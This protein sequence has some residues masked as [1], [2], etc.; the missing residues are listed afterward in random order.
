MADDLRNA[1][2]RKVLRI[3][4]N[5]A[6]GSP[7][8]IPASAEALNFRLRADSRPRPSV[9]PRLRRRR[10][11][12]SQ[13]L[14]KLSSIHFPRSFASG[15]KNSHPSIVKGV[16]LSSASRSVSCTARLLVVRVGSDVR[17]GSNFLVFILQ[18]IELVVNAVLGEQ[19]LVR[20][21]LPNLPFVHH[22]NLVGALNG[23]KPVGDD[24]RGAAFD[25]AAQGVAHPE[26]SFGIYAGRGLVEN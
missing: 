24:H 10:K 18:L 26:F 25:H 21:H 9:R 4:H 12:A 23:G 7:H 1:D 2:D 20:T 22:D 3:D 5:L 15:D 14:D 11:F 17:S 19:L 16:S 6:P 8:A 13:S